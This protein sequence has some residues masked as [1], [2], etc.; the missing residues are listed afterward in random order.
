MN[1]INQNE[2]NEIPLFIIILSL[3]ICASEVV[4]SY[5]NTMR[6]YEDFNT[7]IISHPFHLGSP[8]SLYMLAGFGNSWPGLFQKLA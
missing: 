6:E 8:N 4:A 7:Y 3:L 5:C 1:Q 2:L